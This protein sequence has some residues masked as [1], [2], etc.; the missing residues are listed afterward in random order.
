MLQ[1]EYEYCGDC[2]WNEKS[3]NG[4]S[5]KRF[6]DLF[7]AL[8][9][10]GF[11]AEVMYT[12]RAGH[13]CNLTYA[14]ARDRKDIILIA[15]VGG[16]GTVSKVASG[17]RGST[18]ILGI[19]PMRSRD[20][21][22]RAMGVLRKDVNT[23]VQILLSGVGHKIGAARVEGPAALP[24]PRTRLCAPPTSAMAR[25]TARAASRAGAF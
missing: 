9:A 20:D 1:H 21:V 22:A 5:A 14:L 16:D 17:L 6:A 8:A 11:I 23:T 18:K 19:I 12:E 4:R 13:V 3:H 24:P 2:E 10:A 25:P 15:A 7:D